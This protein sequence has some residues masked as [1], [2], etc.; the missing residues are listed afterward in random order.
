M[1]PISRNASVEQLVIGTYPYPHIFNVYQR[2]MDT[3]TDLARV[4]MELGGLM[5]NEDWSA[6]RVS[7]NQ[8]ASIIAHV[9]RK[10]ITGRTAKLLLSMK[11]EG[12]T[13]PIERIIAD[14][15]ML[16]QPLS[17]QEYEHLANTLFEEKKDVVKD[18]VEKKRY[19]KLRY[20]VGQMM[21]RS[22]E[23]TVEPDKAIEVMREL[24][25]LPSVGQ[26]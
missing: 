23:G 14:E 22:A 13:R 24:L 26:D 1:N 11:F 5:K 20:F 7:S 17:R 10:Q 2:V 12:D 6:T 9:L 16:L 4:L 8:L 21:A 18:I 25:H 3:Y 15:D 19:N